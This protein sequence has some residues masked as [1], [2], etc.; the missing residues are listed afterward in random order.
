[1]DP[2]V[3]E[4]RLLVPRIVMSRH[5]QVRAALA[6]VAIPLGAVNVALIARVCG[7]QRLQDTFLT[8]R[9]LTCRPVPF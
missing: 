1:M 2:V 4:A 3:E 5:N 6:V 7:W 9:P 8:S